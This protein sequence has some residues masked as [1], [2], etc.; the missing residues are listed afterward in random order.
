[1]GEGPRVQKNPPKFLPDKDIFG[2]KMDANRSWE[3]ILDT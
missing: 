3:A 1:M 2:E